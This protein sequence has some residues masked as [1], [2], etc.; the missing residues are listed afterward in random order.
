MFF[1]KKWLEDIYSDIRGGSSSEYAILVALIAVVIIGA[2]V[3]L[4]IVVLR[5]FEFE[6]P[7]LF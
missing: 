2:L 7:I 5:L 4:G 1:L 6:F 3:I